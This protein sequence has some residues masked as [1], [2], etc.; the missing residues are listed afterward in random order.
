MAETVQKWRR[1]LKFAIIGSF[2]F[3][4]STF[5]AQ[6][7]LLETSTPL[8]SNLHGL[9]HTFCQVSSLIKAEVPETAKIPK[10]DGGDGSEMAETAQI[11]NNWSISLYY[12]NF[13]C[14]IS[15]PRGLFTFLSNLH[16][17]HH[18]FIL[19]FKFPL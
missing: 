9:N 5:Y 13:L 14:S 11:C 15:S 4:I 1:W 7:H 8:F 16:G 6:F 3:S 12:I 18:T 2:L 17:L 19:F 10:G